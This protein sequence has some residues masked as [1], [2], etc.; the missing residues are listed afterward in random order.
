MSRSPYNALMNRPLSS[1]KNSPLRQS[2]PTPADGALSTE[3]S[4]G[5]GLNSMLRNSMHAVTPRPPSTDPSPPAA[6]SSPGAAKSPMAFRARRFNHANSGSDSDLSVSLPSTSSSLPDPSRRRSGSENLPNS[7]NGQTL[8]SNSI[9]SALGRQLSSTSTSSSVSIRPNTSPS[10]TILAAFG[11]QSVHASLDGAVVA[12]SPSKALR[13]KSSETN[14][15]NGGGSTTSTTASGSGSKVLRNRLSED[16][17]G[18]AAGAP[19]LSLREKLAILQRNN[20]ALEQQLAEAANEAQQRAAQQHEA[21]V[22]AMSALQQRV[23]ALEG[24][25]AAQQRSATELTQRNQQLAEAQ[26]QLQGQLATANAAIRAA[27]ATS[28]RGNTVDAEA[29]GGT[30][31]PSRGAPYKAL[32]EGGPQSPRTPLSWDNLP[33]GSPGSSSSSSRDSTGVAGASDN[34]PPPLSPLQ[35]LQ[36]GGGGSG[37]FKGVV[38]DDI[39]PPHPH[40]WPGSPN[41]IAAVDATSLRPHTAPHADYLQQR[42]ASQSGYAA[43]APSQTYDGSLPSDSASLLVVCHSEPELAQTGAGGPSGMADG[44]RF[45]HQGVLAM[46]CGAAAGSNAAAAVAAAAVASGSDIYLAG[47]GPPPASPVAAAAGLSGAGVALLARQK[48]IIA[49]LRQQLQQKDS[50]YAFL[51]NE[52]SEL[53]GQLKEVEAA[54]R[55]Y[56]ARYAFMVLDQDLDGH[57]R[58]DQVGSFDMFGCYSATVLEY[59]F[60]HWRFASGF[61]GY[62]NMDDFV[63]FVSLSDDRATRDSQRFWFMVLDLDGDGAVSAE[64]AKWFYDSVEKDESTFVVGFEDLWHQLLDMTQPANKRRGF[65]SAELWKCKLGAGVIGLL[66]NHNNMLLHRTT[67]EWGRGDF[68]L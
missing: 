11:G 48:K 16:A 53:E 39:L 51:A 28:R 22:T 62:L 41:S 34:Q 42:S 9:G 68:P 66:L 43:N 58:V 12:G 47:S 33:S 25:L 55:E 19:T 13:P 21:H 45:T 65:T 18:H 30:T 54:K 14:A 4:G 24:Q 2:A 64:D 61:K 15:S 44:Q 67:A 36:H 32:A 26:Q 59:A 7:P 50:A 56:A 57:I 63:K 37:S 29:E 10:S 1:G 52:H 40:V 27:A 17:G 46:T 3:G 60:K 35:L 8:H 38:A 31:T 6:S 5:W 23:A 49:S 20:K